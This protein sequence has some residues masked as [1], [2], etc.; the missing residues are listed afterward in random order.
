MI[1]PV[2]KTPSFDTSLFSAITGN[3][4]LRKFLC[5]VM[6]IAEYEDIDQVLHLGQVPDYSEE[7]LGVKSLSAV[8]DPRIPLGNVLKAGYDIFR[9]MAEIE[10]EIKQNGGCQLIDTYICDSDGRKIKKL[11]QSCPDGYNFTPL[12]PEFIITTTTNI[13]TDAFNSHA[14][15]FSNFIKDYINNGW[16]ATLHIYQKFP[17]FYVKLIKDSETLYFKYYSDTRMRV[18]Q[19]LGLTIN[20]RDDFAWDSEQHWRS[21]LEFTIPNY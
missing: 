18:S 12:T 8:G 15:R 20:I 13:I 17:L 11:E 5:E 21:L 7:L 1:D 4:D 10:L 3:G 16:A 9:P 14:D 6:K 19:N 2:C